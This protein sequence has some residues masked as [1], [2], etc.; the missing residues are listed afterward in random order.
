MA[1]IKFQ[2]AID[3]LRGK[4]NI[5][6]DSWD[7][8][9][10]EVHAK[11]FTVAGATK[12]DLLADFRQAVD[13]AISNGQSI[14]NFRKSFNEIVQK[15]GWTYKGTPGWRSRVIYDTNMRTAH[16]AGRWQQIQRTKERRPYLQYLTAGDE[17][18]RP[19]HRRWSKYVLLINDPWWDTHYPP[20]GWG[21]RCTVRT[22]S[23]T[24]VR[25]MGLEIITA[26]DLEL[27]DIINTNTGEVF[28]DVP[29]GIDP[30]WDYNVGKSWL[31]PG[32][33]FGQKLPKLPKQMRTAALNDAAG[34][35]DD[36]TS[37]YTDWV[38]KL[39]SQNEAIG[40]IQTIGYMTSQTVDFLENRIT[41]PTTALV[42]ISDGEILNA[43]N[44]APNSASANIIKSLPDRLI[45]QADILWDKQDQAILFAISIPGNRRQKLLFRI[46]YPEKRA[47][48]RD[49]IEQLPWHELKDGALVNVNQLSD[50]ERYDTI[51]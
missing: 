21:C 49:L 19:E 14:G 51:R 2:E 39:T 6:S 12:S 7:S 40:E 50:T 38:E 26:P 48:N 8:M 18:V 41:L 31:G 11:A 30:G 17:R 42:T 4:L 35:L 46:D 16:M 27:N 32:I 44:R 10:G 36:L 33:S 24:Q 25:R 29:I 45:N 9:L 20:N 28:K 43:L 23:L 34:R 1:D 47:S 22:L 15:H 13:D 37:E 5:P 3:F